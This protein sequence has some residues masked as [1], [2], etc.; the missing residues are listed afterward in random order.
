MQTV[1][2]LT[3]LLLYVVTYGGLISLRLINP[4]EQQENRP[5]S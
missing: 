2:V 1:Y 5:Q 4:Y 3:M